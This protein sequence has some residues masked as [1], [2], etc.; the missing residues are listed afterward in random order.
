MLI[1][2]KDQLSPA[3]YDVITLCEKMGECPLH[4]IYMDKNNELCVT[5]KGH[6]PEEKLPYIY[7]HFT[8]L[9]EGD[10]LLR[11]LVAMQDYQY[12]NHHDI[13]RITYI[14]TPDGYDYSRFFKK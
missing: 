7:Q 10:S 13:G 5:F 12:S 14:F 2:S 4:N 9:I 8:D 6:I 11:E 1:N 3:M